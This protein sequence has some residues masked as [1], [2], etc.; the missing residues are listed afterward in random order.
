[1]FEVALRRMQFMENR[2]QVSKSDYAARRIGR[3]VL[4]SDPAV[5]KQE[6]RGLGDGVSRVPEKA[7]GE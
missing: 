5:P 1:M 6:L 7:H 2:R 3:V 4:G